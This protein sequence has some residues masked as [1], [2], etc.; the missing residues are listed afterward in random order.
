MRCVSR[1]LI[2][3]CRVARSF[4]SEQL[5][6]RKKRRHTGK[7]NSTVKLTIQCRF[8]RLTTPLDNNHNQYYPVLL[9]LA[10]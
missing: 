2:I 7:I 4:Q 9:A 1:A 5:Y 3:R 6:K 8:T 10:E